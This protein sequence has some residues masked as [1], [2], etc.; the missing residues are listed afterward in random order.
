MGE[1]KERKTQTPPPPPEAPINI[2][3]LGRNGWDTNPRRTDRHCGVCVSGV[4]SGESWSQ[5]GAA[6]ASVRA[7]PPSSQPSTLLGPS[8]RY[9]D[10]SPPPPLRVPRTVSSLLKEERGELP[11]TLPQP[12]APAPVR[13]CSASLVPTWARGCAG[14]SMGRVAVRGVLAT[15]LGHRP[16]TCEKQGSA[17]VA[18]GPRARA[19]R[20]KG[21]QGR[22]RSSGSRAPT[23]SRLGPGLTDSSELRAALS[24]RRDHRAGPAMRTGRGRPSP[25]A[26]RLL[27]AP[28]LSLAPFSHFGAS[29]R[30]S[31]PCFCLLSLQPPRSSLARLASSLP[32]SPAHPLP[33]PS[34]P[35]QAPP[36]HV[37]P[38]AP[39]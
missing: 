9:P 36:H 22:G 16:G 14:G 27:R 2:Y 25:G 20:G 15:H 13:S 19:R 32:S 29:A 10:F 1:G 37:P 8:P 7:L 12:P 18:E 39:G 30:L 6:A 5:L 23:A 35:S 34:S 4:G 3:T 26:T 38:P 31:L 21:A 11:A 33:A 28:P 17:G 24:P